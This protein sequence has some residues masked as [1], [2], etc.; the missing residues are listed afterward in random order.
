[1]WDEKILMKQLDDYFKNITKEQLLKDLE[2]CDCLHLVEDV[3]EAPYISAIEISKNRKYNPHYGDNR[4]CE[5]NHVYY[6]HFDSYENNYPCGCKYC[7]CDTFK[8]KVEK[9]GN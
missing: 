5:C 1:M 2:E 8:E 4:V 7:Q 3:K 6:R 9:D